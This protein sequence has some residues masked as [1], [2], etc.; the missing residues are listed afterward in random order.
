MPSIPIPTSKVRHSLSLAQMRQ[1]LHKAKP[2]RAVKDKP[3][4]LKRTYRLYKEKHRKLVVRLRY[5]SLTNYSQIINSWADIEDMTGIRQSTARE[6]IVR[7]HANNN[8]TKMGIR[9][10]RPPQQVPVEVLQYLKASLHENRFFPLRARCNLIKE[11]F[12]VTIYPDH[13]R[14][15]FK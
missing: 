11:M 9:K 1:F 4:R 6:M 12:D 5:G 3:I 7:F 8:S 15:I 13:L 10:G 2:Q 14:R